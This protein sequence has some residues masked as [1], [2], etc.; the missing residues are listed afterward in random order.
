MSTLIDDDPETGFFPVL[1]PLCSG[2]VRWDRKKY[3]H[4]IC[5]DCNRKEAAYLA[6]LEPTGDQCDPLRKMALAKLQGT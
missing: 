1:C 2:F 6:S 4:A 3:H 5:N